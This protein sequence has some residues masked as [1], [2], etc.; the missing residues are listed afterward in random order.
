[1]ADTT[2]PVNHLALTRRGALTL[3]AAA[4]TAALAGPASAHD[5]GHAHHGLPDTVALPDGLQPEGITSGPG[6]TFYVGSV[7]DGRI[8]T[9]NL[10]EVGTTVLLPAATG[11]SLRGLFHDRHTGL[12]WAVGSL[13]A[14]AHVW[15][16]DDTSGAVVADVMVPGGGF[17]NDLVITRRAV[18]VTDSAVDRLTR[19]A[20]DRRGL[21]RG[22]DPTFLPLGG[23]WPATAAGTFG[24]N[25]IRELSDESLIINNSTAGGLWE[26]N[27]RTGVTREIVVSGGPRPVSG[28][29][30]VLRGHTLFD[31]R[32]SGASDVSVFRLRRHHGRWTATAQGLLTDPTLDVPS[33]ATFA[34]GSLWAVNA[35]FG[36][37]SPATAPYWI[38]R[39]PTG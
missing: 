11:R 27:R 1:M 33:T 24:A 10:L 37:A 9:G 20:L 18:W 16:V 3:A 35:R 22:T 32:G 28:D 23:D 8:V 17:L 6:S 38:T 26:V 36:V 12:V 25:G 34:K 21:P 5:D 2:H 19:I 13:G 14:D 7:A 30:L 15:A 39:L 31:V 29:G 4:T